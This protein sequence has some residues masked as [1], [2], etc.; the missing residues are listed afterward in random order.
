MSETAE[1][2]FSELLRRETEA[3]EH[4]EGFNARLSQGLH[5]VDRE[6]G[7]E[8]RRARHWR[9]VLLSAALVGLAITIPALILS[10]SSSTPTPAELTAMAGVIQRWEEVDFLP[11][12]TDY[13]SAD[14]LPEAVHKEMAARRLA[15]A[16]VV[17]TKEFL[18]SHDVNRDHAG[19]LEEF[20]KGGE[21][22]IVENHQQVLK[23][24]YERTELDGDVVVRVTEWHGEVSAYWDDEQQRLTRYHKIDGTPVFEYTL[25]GSGDTWRL[26]SRRQ[27][28]ISADASIDQF[29]PNTPH[30]QQPIRAD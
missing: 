27:V 25:R 19:T 29:G 18:A 14:R 22:I 15:V 2:Q 8:R 3:P 20:H 6:L 23:V 10:G 5:A 24:T 21:P 7:R 13:Y 9:P 16:E 26:V 11:W 1:H 4:G 30:E 12:P 17:G 28:E